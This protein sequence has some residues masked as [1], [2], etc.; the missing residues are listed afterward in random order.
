MQNTTVR[1]AQALGIGLIL[2]IPA[3]CHS[4]RTQLLHRDENNSCWKKKR[5]TGIPITLKVPTHLRVTVVE[6][7]L[8]D[9]ESKPIALDGKEPLTFRDVR[10]NF[11]VT[12]K[13]FTVDL[14]RPAAG[15]LNYTAQFE[16][17]YFKQLQSQVNDQTIEQTSMA[18]QRILQT[19][20]P[21]GLIARRTAA[22]EKPAE[23]TEVDSV[24][25]ATV[26]EIDAPDFELKLEEFL[27]AYLNGT[28]P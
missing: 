18:L 11:L 17:Q 28:E 25:A 24:L 22:D 2:L 8:L 27:N 7:I 13:I 12:E 5:L 15:T 20:A 4:I 16:D 3:G 14:E 6:K 10:Y 26:L 9:K 19:V 21:Q 1:M 23:V